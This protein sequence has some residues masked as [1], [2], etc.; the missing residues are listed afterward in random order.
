MFLPSNITLKFG[1]SGDFVAEM[2]RRLV[3]VQ[4]LAEQAVTSFFDGATVNAV[5]LF[6]QQHGLRADGVADP[7]TL[8]KLNNVIAGTDTDT[9]SGSQ[10]EEEE[11]KKRGGT[12][13]AFAPLGAIAAT[14]TLAF[15]AMAATSQTTQQAPQQ[16]A[17]TQQAPEMAA[18]QIQEPKAYVPPPPPRTEAPPVNEQ[19]MINDQVRAQAAANQAN[20]QFMPPPPS[21]QL[22]AFA[23]QQPPMQNQQQPLQSQGEQPQQQGMMGKAMRFANAVMQKIAD[24]IESK[25]P[26]SA[27]RE[28]QAIGQAMANAGVREAPIPVGP[29]M[30]GQQQTPARGPEQAQVQQRG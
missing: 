20:Q 9:S 1:D 12:A 25:L 2:Q 8:S 29:E 4:C 30:A 27:L 22:A 24:Y 23:Q 7:V 3:I 19:Q 16:Q 13:A 14:G 10:E 26:S 18:P 15:E 28:V 6:Q 21:D 5:T 11:K 17:P